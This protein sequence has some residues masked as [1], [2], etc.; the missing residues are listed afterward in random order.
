MM[1][2]QKILINNEYNIAFSSLIT[3]MY[4]ESS[5]ISKMDLNL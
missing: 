2:F 3:E 4:S 5:E 1:R